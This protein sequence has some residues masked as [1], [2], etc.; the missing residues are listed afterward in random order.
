M[1]SRR[2]VPRL[3]LALVVLLLASCA[4]V[5]RPGDDVPLSA[6]PLEQPV[7]A[8]TYS[9]T[10]LLPSAINVSAPSD[11]Q[12]E[13][14]A[15]VQASFPLVPTDF[16]PI[17]VEPEGPETLDELFQAAPAAFGQ[18][19]IAARACTRTLEVETEARG[20][21]RCCC[22]DT[23]ACKEIVCPLP[24][25]MEALTIRTPEDG[26]DSVR[27]ALIAS[28]INRV[29]SVV[30]S[31]GPVTDTTEMASNVGLLNE[32]GIETFV[33]PEGIEESA[34]VIEQYD[35]APVSIE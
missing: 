20:I 15:A 24:K 28:G 6:I 4:S 9:S 13:V 5:T 23:A 34:L 30:P 27:A 8:T 35:Y 31:D 17:G 33:I 2:A 10:E 26:I 3:C 1:A 25:K 14:M 18:P 11:V 16:N 21:I 7:E 12:N 22:P 32:L 19:L 29:V